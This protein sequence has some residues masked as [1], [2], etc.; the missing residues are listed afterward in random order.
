MTIA[1]RPAPLQS[2]MSPK[3]SAGRQRLATLVRTVE[4]S[5]V[6]PDV[7]L[8]VEKRR[9]R[10]PQAGHSS[11]S[12]AFHARSHLGR[13]AVG[14][15]SGDADLCAATGALSARR[16]SH[17]RDRVRR[18][19][20]AGHTVLSDLVQGEVIGLA[21][22]RTTDSLAGFADDLPRCPPRACT[23]IGEEPQIGVPSP[24]LSRC[25]PGWIAS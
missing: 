1:R 21:K 25:E 7:S 12:G 2:G 14:V 15:A 6:L 4:I 24:G 20:G 9:G 5:A 16:H 13:C 8:F 3:K 17:G 22:D 11:Q 23:Q 10:L 18:S 19:E